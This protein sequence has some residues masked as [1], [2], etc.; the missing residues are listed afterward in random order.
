MTA[1][2]QY[3]FMPT[4]RA[5]AAWR[6]QRWW[7]AL[8]WLLV[9]LT[10]VEAS[11]GEST[12]GEAAVPMPKPQGEMLLSDLRPVYGS[13]PSISVALRPEKAIR[14]LAKAYR[15]V[16]TR[17]IQAGVQIVADAIAQASRT[18]AASAS[19]GQP[20]H[21][22]DWDRLA[23]DLV[24]TM[25]EPH[26]W[27]VWVRG[28]HWASRS[29][30]P[31][32]VFRVDDWIYTGF[33]TVEPNLR[34][35]RLA[36]QWD[37]AIY[38]EWYVFHGRM[39]SLFGPRTVRGTWDLQPW[40]VDE[41]IV[42]GRAKW[43]EGTEEITEPMSFPQQALGW[44]MIGPRSLHSALALYG[45]VATLLAHLLPAELVSS[46]AIPARRPT[47]Y[48]LHDVQG[49]LCWSVTSA[50]ASVRQALMQQGWVDVGHDTVAQRLVTISW[51]EHEV[52]IRKPMDPDVE[53]EETGNATMGVSL[54]A[55]WSDGLANLGNGR[56][57]GS[58][59]IDHRRDAWIAKVTGRS[60][61]AA[62]WAAL[63]LHALPPL[64]ATQHRRP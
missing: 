45:A 37:G 4:P 29:S 10:A 53:D 11:A 64:S 43:M 22:W 16:Y 61:P 18:L 14:D 51:S 47:L 44:V 49:A 38:W 8:A 35:P 24:I 60:G 27:V 23:R 40:G 17:P 26:G 46:L 21:P 52:P 15:G 36:D 28:P 6:Y 56:T 20:A 63:R 9:L 30:V 59:I 12:A 50:D 19:G 31:Q 32:Q 55:N 7:P 13:F 25:Y 54:I 5:P 62:I 3:W 58:L 41:T 57:F 33:I 48:A 42:G 2:M 39:T 34:P 1:M